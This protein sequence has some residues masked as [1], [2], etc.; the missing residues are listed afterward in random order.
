MAKYLTAQEVAKRL[1]FSERRVYRWAESGKIPGVK[2]IEMSGTSRRHF[3][4]SEKAIE[5]FEET[6]DGGETD[7]DTR[8]M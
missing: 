3:L 6:F 4:F 5:E 1:G 2:I 7:G 8:E